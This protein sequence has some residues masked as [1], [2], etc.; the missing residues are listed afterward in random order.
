MT[1]RQ[2]GYYTFYFDNT[3][4]PI[5]SS[6][7]DFDTVNWPMDNITFAF[8]SRHTSYDTSTAPHLQTIVHPM[9]SGFGQFYPNPAEHQ[10]SIAIDLGEGTAC[11]VVLYD[12]LG[13]IVHRS[14]LQ[15]TDR[16][17]F[18]INTDGLPSGIYTAVF[19]CR[20]RCVVRRLAVR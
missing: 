4:P 3:R 6:R 19:Q 11:S 5:D 16:F 12:N 9:E 8:D 10:A 2:G 20:N 18:S 15:G 17:L 14:T 7:Y 1:A 13:R